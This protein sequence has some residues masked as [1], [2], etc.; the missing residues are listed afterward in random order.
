MEKIEELGHPSPPQHCSGTAHQCAAISAALALTPCVSIG[1][2]QTECCGEPEVF[3]KW[4]C[5]GACEVMITQKVNIKI[6]IR[7][8]VEAEVDKS[9]VNCDCGKK[10]CD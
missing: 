9:S 3:C 1:K 6:P 5:S 2:A 7:Y 4:N 8:S 10:H